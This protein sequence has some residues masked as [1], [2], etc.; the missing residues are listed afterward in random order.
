[1]NTYYLLDILPSALNGFSALLI[2]T[3]TSEIHTI[4][5][6]ILHMILNFTEIK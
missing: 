1:M 2:S 3:T 5:I 4:V 6:A